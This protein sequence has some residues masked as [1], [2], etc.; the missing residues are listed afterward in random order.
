MAADF[1]SVFVGVLDITVAGRFIDFDARPWTAGT[2]E[3]RAPYGATI[4]SWSCSI[5]RAIG[6]ATPQAFAT[7]LAFTSSAI[8]QPTTDAQ[9]LSGTGRVVFTTDTAGTSGVVE[10]WAQVKAGTQL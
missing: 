7:P 9:D 4:G 2:F 1:Q 3:Y 6:T 10:V 5:K 8:T